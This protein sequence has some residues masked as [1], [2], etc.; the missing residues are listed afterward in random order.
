MSVRKAPDGRR[1]VELEF[2]LP[3]TPEQVWRAIATG[4]GITSWFY[5]TDVQ[6]REGGAIVFHLDPASDS[7]DSRGVITAWQPPERIAYEER[8]WMPG[9]P[10]VATEMTIEVRGGSCVVRVVH[11]L[12][13]DA[14]D[15]DDQ[16]ESFEAGWPPFF[17]LL[18]ILLERFADQRCATVRVAGNSRLDETELWKRLTTALGAVDAAPGSR[19]VSER[20]GAPRLDGV[21]VGH[22]P[23]SAPRELLLELD[24][25]APGVALV[26]AA[27]WNGKTHVTVAQTL[28]GAGAVDLAAGEEQAWRALLAR[29][30]EAR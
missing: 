18:R 25:P 17:R 4:P 29:V 10:P 24:A 3:G 14:A 7:G 16:L 30:E 27:E 19:V 8:E 2:E 12:F 15:W 13:T 1:T 5:P 23:R 21:V 11:S 28:F 6:E 22:E 9:A 26:A 20:P